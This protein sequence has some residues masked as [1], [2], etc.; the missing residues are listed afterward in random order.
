MQ[1]QAPTHVNYG[2]LPLGFTRN[3][4]FPQQQM[5]C[6]FPSSL[7]DFPRLES[8]FIRALFSTR[9]SQND[10]AQHFVNMGVRP[11]NFIKDPAISVAPDKYPPLKE[12]CNQEEQDIRYLYS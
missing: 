1:S 7:M 12:L 11:Q 8:A 10:Y 3:F 5:L 9:A 2:T 4:N 6:K